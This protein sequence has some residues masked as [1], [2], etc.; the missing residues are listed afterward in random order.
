[1]TI[2]ITHPLK[3]KKRHFIINYAW[4]CGKTQNYFEIYHTDDRFDSLNGLRII[5]I[6]LIGWIIL[7]NLILLNIWPNL[8]IFETL[9]S[10]YNTKCNSFVRMLSIKYT[11]LGIQLQ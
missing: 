6:F 3:N 7:F 10:Y 5:K 9:F 11:S 2:L 8:P 4:N 1:M